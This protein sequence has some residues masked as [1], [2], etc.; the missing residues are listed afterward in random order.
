MTVDRSAQKSTILRF[1]Q[2]ELSKKNIYIWQKLIGGSNNLDLDLIPDPVDQFGLSNFIH[3][4]ARFTSRNAL[5][6]FQRKNLQLSSLARCDDKLG[7]NE[8]KEN[9]YFLSYLYS[10]QF[11]SKTV[12]L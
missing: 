2:K 7:F 3:C 11:V 10:L 9:E 8:R 5:D 4:S 12:S 6:T 1:S